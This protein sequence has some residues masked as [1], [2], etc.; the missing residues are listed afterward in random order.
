MCS[1]FISIYVHSNQT[2]AWSKI[3]VKFDQDHSNETTVTCLSTHLTSFAVLMSIQNETQ[4]QVAMYICSYSYVSKASYM[5]TTKLH[6][7][8]STN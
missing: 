2:G 1:Y 7:S 5:H 6:K 3:G 4:P 8:R